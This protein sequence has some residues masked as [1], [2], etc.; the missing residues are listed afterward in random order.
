MLWKYNTGIL[1]DSVL[2]VNLYSLKY[3]DL[4]QNDNPEVEIFPKIV[5]SVLRTVVD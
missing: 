4:S 3:K 5:S 2:R 1:S